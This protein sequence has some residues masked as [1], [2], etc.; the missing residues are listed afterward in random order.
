[1]AHL[2]AAQGAEAV[3]AGRRRGQTGP[4]PP[5]TH[6]DTILLRRAVTGMCDALRSTGHKAGAAC[7][8]GWTL[9]ELCTSHKRARTGGSASAVPSGCG[10]ERVAATASCMGTICAQASWNDGSSQGRRL[11]AQQRSRVIPSDSQQ[12]G[13][14]Q[15]VALQATAW[16]AAAPAR[17]APPPRHRC[18]P[19]LLPTLALLRSLQPS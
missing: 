9:P 11:V 10:F 3:S 14:Q 16:V 17:R 18:N 2:P 1:M 4:I 5:G 7:T 19:F 12:T 6:V 13:M 15:K 8:P